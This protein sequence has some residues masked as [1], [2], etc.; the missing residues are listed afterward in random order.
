MSI[1]MQAV[2]AV[3]FLLLQMTSAFS[4]AGHAASQPVT[5]RRERSEGHT[6][7]PELVD[8]LAKTANETC[9]QVEAVDNYIE[10]IQS[11]QLVPVP[12]FADRHGFK[13]I[14]GQYN[15]DLSVA[16]EHC[17]PW[18]DGDNVVASLKQVVVAAQGFEPKFSTEFVRNQARIEKILENH[19]DIVAMEATVAVLQKDISEAKE[20]LKAAKFQE[21]ISYLENVIRTKEE[22]INTTMTEHNLVLGK[23]EL[24]ELVE[25]LEFV[26]AGAMDIESKA[27]TANTKITT[28]RENLIRDAGA[29]KRHRTNAQD[30]IVKL[31]ARETEQQ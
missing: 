30:G 7:S 11:R 16:R 29:F 13:A 12:S 3:L 23:L 5:A 18:R 22:E 26:K 9:S 10:N 1:K 21:L 8:N 2:G 4:T 17:L 25:Y 27:N 28:F 31:Q 20:V 24:A 6:C 14:L 15:G 19:E